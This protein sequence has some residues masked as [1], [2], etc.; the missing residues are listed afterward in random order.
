MSKAF[1]RGMIEYFY[2]LARRSK[3]TPKDRLMNKADEGSGM[4]V[5]STIFKVRDSPLYPL[6]SV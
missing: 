3:R 5:E 1:M 6:G 4:L 2:L